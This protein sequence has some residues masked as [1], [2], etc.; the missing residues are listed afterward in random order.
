MCFSQIF[1]LRYLNPI[2]FS[3]RVALVKVV[4]VVVVAVELVG[5]HR[6]SGCQCFSR[7][8]AQS[9]SRI[10][11]CEVLFFFVDLICLYHPEAQFKL[12]PKH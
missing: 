3:G 4:V 9:V 2:R 5:V 12:L 7:A 10:L 11:G 8:N 6:N 1:F